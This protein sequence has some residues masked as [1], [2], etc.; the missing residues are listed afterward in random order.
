MDNH[1]DLLLRKYGNTVGPIQVI[2]KEREWYIQQLRSVSSKLCSGKQET[3]F[4]CC[5]KGQTGFPGWGCETVPI[6]T[7]RRTFGQLCKGKFH[8]LTDIYICP[9]FWPTKNQDDTIFHE[10]GRLV[11]IEGVDNSHNRD[12]ISV[13]DQFTLSICPFSA[14]IRKQIWPE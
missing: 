10:L 2:L 1:F 12:D 8:K 6:Q 5:A 7:C 4:Y 3:W 14:N 11:G 9:S 13:W